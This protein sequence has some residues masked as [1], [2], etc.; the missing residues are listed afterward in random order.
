MNARQDAAW[1]NLSFYRGYLPPADRERVKEYVLLALT[2][3]APKREN[4]CE[5]SP[6]PLLSVSRSADYTPLQDILRSDSSPAVGFINNGRAT[7]AGVIG[8]DI[9]SIPSPLTGLSTSPQKPNAFAVQSPH[10]APQITLLE[11]SVANAIGAVGSSLAVKQRA[12]AKRFFMIKKSAL[13]QIPHFKSFILKVKKCLDICPNL[14]CTPDC[15]N[16][17]VDLANKDL[18]ELSAFDGLDSI[19]VN[20]GNLLPSVS[21]KSADMHKTAG[22]LFC[23]G[24]VKH[25]ITQA[26]QGTQCRFGDKCRYGSRCLFI[27]MK[28]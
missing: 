8:Q 4:R 9:P 19:I 17:H 28:N 13:S 1:K 16:V 21:V 3:E 20:R 14:A 22:A 12:D 11:S 24:L 2:D 6:P 5:S 7:D 10:Q 23:C 26:V 15:P 27:H 25:G 18:F